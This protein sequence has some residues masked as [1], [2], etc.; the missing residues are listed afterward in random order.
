VKKILISILIIGVVAAI[1]IGGTAAYFYSS[2]SVPGA[3]TTATFNVAA[4]N[5]GVPLVFDK[6]VPGG[7]AVVKYVRVV[8]SGDVGAYVRVNAGNWSGNGTLLNALHVK[9]TLL[10]AT[11][12]PG[13]GGNYPDGN[14]Y[15]SYD[16]PLVGLYIDNV[17]HNN[18][19][20]PGQIGVYMVEVTLP[21]GGP[22]NSIQN[23][24]AGADLIMDATQSVGQ[25]NP[26]NPGNPGA[27]YW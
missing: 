19:I 26:G 9:V 17:G 1:A 14:T 15:P 11:Q 25:P 4:D 27:I 10:G 7:P 3:F 6:L 23:V 20:M 8:N 13:V 18:P 12:Y 16:G 5:A 2:N 21:F 22:D 24:S